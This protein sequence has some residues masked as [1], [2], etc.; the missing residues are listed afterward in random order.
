MG[1]H[2]AE[3]RAA[4]IVAGED[5]YASEPYVR[6]LGH[7]GSPIALPQAGGWLL[8]RTS[9]AGTDACAP[10]PLL[11]CQ[12]PQALAS[13]F[14]A[15]M[16][17]GG[18]V[19]VTAVCDPMREGYDEALRTAFRDHWV[20]Y[21]DHFVVD[22]QRPLEQT[23]SNHHARKVK[24][25]EK[26]VTVEWAQGSALEAWE[27]DWQSLY[28]ALIAHHDIQGPAAFPPASLAAQLRVPGARATRARIAEQ[29]VSMV[30]WYPAGEGM[31]Y[32]LAGTNSEGYAASATYALFAAALRRFREEGCAW[33][34]LGAGA[35]VRADESSGLTAFKAGWATHTRTA[36]L[37][38]RILDPE[39]YQRWCEQ[40]GVA[41]GGDFFPAYRNVSARAREGGDRG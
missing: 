29:T 4:R 18:P 20:A 28:A 35:G 12:T 16:Q 2:D 1:A 15:L 3:G 32:H 33:T 17:P 9:A 23:L 22:L 7:I 26:R 10:Y 8:Q 14:D 41:A 19:S 6:A 40:V 38:G 31:R 39:A 37:G 34:H 5:G 25:G 11:V 24:R 36:F 27:A 30:V 13:D 21:K